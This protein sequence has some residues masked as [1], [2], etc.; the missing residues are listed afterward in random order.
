MDFHDLVWIFMDLHGF[1]IIFTGLSWIC[2][3]F[4]G[5]PMDFH[6]FPLIFNGFAWICMDL[7]GYADKLV[8]DGRES[9]ICI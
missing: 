3:D 4:H 2:I 1:S 5:V 6:A 7:H 8:S 9:H